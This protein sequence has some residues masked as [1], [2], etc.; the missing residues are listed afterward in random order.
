MLALLPPMRAPIFLTLMA[1]AKGLVM[2]I[3][4][5]PIAHCSY[6]PPRRD[7]DRPGKRHSAGRGEA[8][9]QFYSD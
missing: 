4:T 7:T 2:A 6:S 8:S 1:L 3:R 5:S 9:G